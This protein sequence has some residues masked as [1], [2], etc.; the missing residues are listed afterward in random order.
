MVSERMYCK[1]LVQGRKS[2][3]RSMPLPKQHMPSESTFQM[4]PPA[5]THYKLGSVFCLH[6]RNKLASWLRCPVKI[7]RDQIWDVRD[8]STG[9]ATLAPPVRTS[10]SSTKLKG[11]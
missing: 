3:R 1:Y 7:K 2:P 10:P 6:H 5:F 8:L 11:S 9:N 4:C